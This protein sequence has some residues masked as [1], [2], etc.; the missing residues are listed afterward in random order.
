M[1]ASEGTG[2]KP[3]IAVPAAQALKRAHLEA[4]NR[5]LERDPSQ[6]DRL[7]SIIEGLKKEL[8]AP[9]PRP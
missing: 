2:V 8:E 7:W 1:P 9:T 3:D 5:Q 6:K 4:L